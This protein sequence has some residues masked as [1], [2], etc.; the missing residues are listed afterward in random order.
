MRKR[1]LGCVAAIAWC[2]AAS[3]QS[4]PDCKGTYQVIRAD[5]IK[6]GKLDV[7]RKAVADHQAWY[8]A[9]GFADKILVARVLAPDASGQPVFSDAKALSIH[10]ETPEFEA[11]MAKGA[12]DDDAWHA[13]VAEYQDSSTITATTIACVEDGNK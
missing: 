11:S 6:P 2:G 10:I 9:H 1:L 13:F 4:L 5:D 7:F 8:V 3:A 12:P